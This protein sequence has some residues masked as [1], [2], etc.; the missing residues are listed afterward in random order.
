[1]AGKR[2]LF[3]S[4][5][6]LDASVP[7]L[8]AQFE[9]LLAGPAR[10]CAALY[11]LGDL[12]ETYLGDDDDE[13]AQR[14]ACAALRRLTDAGTPCFVVRGNRDFLLAEAFERR[15]GCRLLPDPAVVTLGALRIVLTHGDPLCIADTRYLRFRGLVRDPAVQRAFLA[16][17]LATRRAL[18]RAA[19]AGSRE[20]TRQA[21]A[22]I[23]D[24]DP[25]AVATLLHLADAPLL[26]HGHTHRPGDHAVPLPGRMARRMVLAD[27]QD[28]GSALVVEETGH[29]ERLTLARTRSGSTVSSASTS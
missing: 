23:L 9:E 11:I 1:M 12:F 26:I 19:R 2:H 14:A 13:P 5:L 22:Q 21:P 27:W 16:L 8:C 29:Y 10:G 28:A 25:A 20:H 24:V 17:P 15:T 3:V 18:A 6:H 7:H 4:D